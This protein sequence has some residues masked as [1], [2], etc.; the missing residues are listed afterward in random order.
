MPSRLFTA[1][2]VVFWLG[3]TALLFYREVLPMMLAED[4]PSYLINLTDEIGSPKANWFLF[5]NKKPAGKCVSLIAME[6]LSYEF[7]CS[8]RFSQLSFPG[9]IL[10]H[11][12][13]GA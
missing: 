10:I 2:V 4:S 5:L 8:M 11:Q 13:D 3:M 12:M 1:T 7:R 6:G 9:G